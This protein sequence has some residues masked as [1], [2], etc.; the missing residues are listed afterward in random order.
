MCSWSTV[1]TW[2]CCTRSRTI[3]FEKYV[4]ICAPKNQPPPRRR[5]TDDRT[6]IALFRHPRIVVV[7]VVAATA[8]AA[9]AVQAQTAAVHRRRIGSGIIVTRLG[10]CFV[11]ASGMETSSLLNLKRSAAESFGQQETAANDVQ[12][13]REH[14]EQ[15]QEQE[16]DEGEGGETHRIE[17]IL[18]HYNDNGL[19]K[20]SPWC[21]I[22]TQSSSLSALCLPMFSTFH[23]VIS[24]KGIRGTSMT[25][26]QSALML[27]VFDSQVIVEGAFRGP[28]TPLEMTFSILD[29]DRA[30]SSC[31]RA[32]SL[33]LF[34]HR[35]SLYVASS[36]DD[37]TGVARVSLMMPEENLNIPVMMY[38]NRIVLGESFAKKMQHSRTTSKVVE[39]SLTSDHFSVRFR[40]LLGGDL[41]FSW[42]LSTTT[43]PTETG[44]VVPKNPRSDLRAVFSLPTIQACLRVF[45]S[46]KYVSISMPEKGDNDQMLPLL[47][48]FQVAAMGVVNFFIAPNSSDDIDVAE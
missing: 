13:K 19:Q 23:W 43:T 36:E 16:Q 14:Q 6:G 47:L 46:A 31:T 26:D 3:S 40:Q 39:F 10:G 18:T 41:L 20:Q 12:S 30:L 22:T 34:S 21:L 37:V 44:S 38:T 35:N 28:S 17:S 11:R 48:S 27:W 1:C 8:A 15:E 32:D 5:A 2:H 24:D 45:R 42:P 7:V 29:L 25:G 9:T 4:V 33:C